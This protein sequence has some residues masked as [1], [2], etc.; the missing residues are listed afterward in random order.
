MVTGIAAGEADAEP[1]AARK[2]SVVGLAVNSESPPTVSVTRTVVGLDELLTVLRLKDVS[3]VPGIS[4]AVF[5]ETSSG[6]GDPAVRFRTPMGLTCSHDAALLVLTD[7]IA[8]AVAVTWM[9]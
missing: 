7:T 6:V 3:Y 8:A 5:T 4:A 9:V 1:G 2:F